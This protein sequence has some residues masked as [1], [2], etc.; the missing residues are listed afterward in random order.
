MPPGLVVEQMHDEG[1][2]KAQ[3]LAV[4]ILLLPCCLS[5]PDSGR[6][7]VLPHLLHSDPGSE[8][9]GVVPGCGSGCIDSSPLNAQPRT[10]L[11]L[12][13]GAHLLSSAHLRGPSHSPDSSHLHK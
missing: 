9:L 4:M 12:P 5:S 2:M 1:K 11:D 3:V 6:K 10:N 7:G 13:Q 8:F